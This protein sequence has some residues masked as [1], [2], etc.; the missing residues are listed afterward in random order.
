M[1][2]GLASV[3]HARLADTAALSSRR[4][5]TTG[6]YAVSVTV[7]FPAPAQRGAPAAVGHQQPLETTQT[8]KAIPS[9]QVS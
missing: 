4:L 9:R 8:Q 7:T 2:P 3:P 6:D 5:A 1:P